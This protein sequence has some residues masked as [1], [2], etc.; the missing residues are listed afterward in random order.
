MFYKIFIYFLIYIIDRKNNLSIKLLL[1]IFTT[2]ECMSGFKANHGSGKMTKLKKVAFFFLNT[3]V[4]IFIIG[5]IAIGSIQ[6]TINAEKLFDNSL[7]FPAVVFAPPLIY[8]GYKAL[9]IKGATEFLLDIGG[10]FFMGIIC[11]MMVAYLHQRGVNAFA[12]SLLIINLVVSSL[13]FVV[14]AYGAAKILNERSVIR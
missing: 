11:A 10:D 1:G 3:R 13:D 4:W 9:N 2:T 12:M 6:G 14:T 5:I 8:S 7:F